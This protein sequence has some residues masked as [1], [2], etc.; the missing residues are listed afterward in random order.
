MQDRV[1]SLWLPN[2]CSIIHII[3]KDI[4]NNVVLLRELLTIFFFKL[5]LFFMARQFILECVTMCIWYF[6][7]KKDLLQKLLQHPVFEKQ[8]FCNL[9][10]CA[11]HSLEVCSYYKTKCVLCIDFC[12]EYLIFHTTGTSVSRLKNLSKK[13]CFFSFLN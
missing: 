9:R 1:T 5:F 7:I 10:F 11:F 6:N 4:F 13:G 12:L 2:V 3:S 8:L